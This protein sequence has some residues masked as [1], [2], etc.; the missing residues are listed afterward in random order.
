MDDVGRAIQERLHRRFVVALLHPGAIQAHSGELDAG[1]QQVQGLALDAQALVGPGQHRIV[2]VQSG[3]APQADG[4]LAGIAQN[5]HVGD[6]GLGNRPGLLVALAVVR[7]NAAV[8]RAGGLLNVQ[9][10]NGTLPAVRPVQAVVG[11]ADQHHMG[12]VDGAA[13]ELQA[14]VQ[15]VIDLNVIDAGAAAH[16]LEGDAVQLV[17]RIDIGAGELDDDIAQ[18]AAVVVGVVAAEQAGAGLALL[19]ALGGA[20]GGAFGAVVDG[21]VAVDDQAAPQ[22]LGVLRIGDGAVDVV[23]RRHGDGRVP[24][25]VGFDSGASGD[26]QEVLR[27]IADDGGAGL[28]VQHPR[29]RIAAHP[30]LAVQ[31][32]VVV[33]GQAD[34]AGEGAGELAGLAAAD[35]GDFGGA[36]RAAEVRGRVGH[37]NRP[38]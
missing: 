38:A 28:D 5:G 30:H 26:D 19:G 35:G 13:E 18:G 10:L 2:E 33:A 1:V 22:P 9:V 24:G 7:F 36:R 3:A 16:A 6:V 34:I 14:V 23:Q 37:A 25:A 15:V 29:G 17:L 8:P 27:V 31:D 4:P 20:A 12:G 21:R 32:V 11:V